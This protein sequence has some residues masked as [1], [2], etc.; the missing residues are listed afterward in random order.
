MSSRR[1]RSDDPQKAHR[2]LQ[3]GPILLAS[4]L[5]MKRFEAEKYVNVAANLGALSA[6][7]AQH[8]Q[9]PFN[10]QL[11][12]AFQKQLLD[13]AEECHK[14][15]LSIAARQFEKAAA[16]IGLMTPARGSFFALQAS[17][18][19]T[20]LQNAVTSEMEDHLFL[21]VQSAK[22]KYYEQTELFG[23]GVALQFG[24][25]EQD[26]RA[27]GNCYASDNNTACV[28]HCMRVLEKGLHAFAGHLKVPFVI[29]VEL[30]NWQN[31]IELI[32]KEIKDR[33]KSLPKGIAK[34]DELKFLSGAAIEFGYFKEAWRNHVAHS[35]VT[36]DDIEALRIMSH[37]HQFMDE[38]AN[39][40]LREP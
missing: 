33:E 37:V 26:I 23:E 38:L 28:F 25:T 7:F 18:M 24:S 34:S 22:A 12:A 4:W 6:Q 8:P 39:H 9:T 29:P 14:L 13:R 1:I 11:L 40:G 5:D 21:W 10:Q 20:F 2:F 31:I 27:A 19:I 30:Q 36:Y 3:D 32:Q 35:R 15:G 17:A 16:D